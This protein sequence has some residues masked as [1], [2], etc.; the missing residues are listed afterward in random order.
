MCAASQ[1]LGREA[2]ACER[3]EDRNMSANTVVIYGLVQPDGS[4]QLE[5]KIPLPA[6]KVQI[7]VQ[8]VP[9]PSEGDPFFDMLKGIWA[10][11]TQAGFTP[12]SVE[13]M[14]AQRRQLHGESDQE[15]MEAG[16]LQEECR[17]LR[18]EAESSAGGRE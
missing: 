4:L 5:G 9:E 10:A 7:T 8:A 6:G 17:R 18:E 13:E 2:T 15:I 1:P 12:R 16:R 11:R 3:M 14:E